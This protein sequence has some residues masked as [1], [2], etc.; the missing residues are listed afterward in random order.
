MTATYDGRLV[1]T[2]EGVGACCR[3]LDR[4]VFQGAVYRTQKGQM[5]LRFGEKGKGYEIAY[6]PFCGAKAELR[7]CGQ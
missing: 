3:N 4:L 6:C 2:S 5:A 1:C 7:G